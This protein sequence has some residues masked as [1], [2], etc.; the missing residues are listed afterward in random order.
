MIKNEEK[1]LKRC[2]EAVENIV[3][4]FCIC[5]TGS[6]DKSLEIA[7]EFLK[8]HKGCLT[9]EPWKNFG[10]N[11]TV[12][13]QNAQKYIKKKLKWNTSKVY[14]LLLD[15][16]MVFV[17]NN[18]KEQKLTETGY[19]IIQLNG[20]LEYYNCRFVRMDFPWK[21]VGVTHEYWDGPTE[22][23]PKSVCYINDVN[24]GG[25]KHDKFERD[26]KLLRQ[27]LIDEPENVRYLFYLAQTLKCTRNFTESIKYYK[28]R[29]KSGGWHEEVWYSHYMIGECYLNLNNMIKFEKWMQLAHQFHPAR[30]ESLAKLTEHFRIHGLHYK[31]YH[32]AKI[33]DSIPF[34]QND[35]LF[36]E[37][38]IYNGKFLY[39]KSILDYYV[40]QDKKIGLRDSFN[41]LLK[42]GEH[43]NNVISNLK[44]Y[45]SPIFVD[46]TPL[47]IPQVFGEDFRPSAVSVLDYPMANIRFV[48]Y[49]PPLDGGFRTKN[50]EDVQTFNAYI[51]IETKE[52]KLMN[53]D[54]V[55]LP[56][57]PT[58]VKGL[59]DI[60]LTKRNNEVWFTATNIRE[61][62]PAVRVITGKYNFENG[63]Y[64]NTSVLK[65]PKN[66]DCEKNW[67]P[68]KDT[69]LMIYGW[70]PYCLIDTESNITL[71]IPTPPLFS[72]FR[73]SA[74]PVKFTDNTHICLVHFV[75]YTKIR[76]YYHC[77][78]ELD[79]NYKPIKLSLP[80]VFNS[81]SI[82]YCLSI[83]K[84]DDVIE[85]FPG[86][87]ESDPHKVRINISTLEWLSF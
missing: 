5:D 27:G 87:M 28:K 1:I 63:E 30:T 65:S 43:I 6:T 22:S 66:L 29:I 79:Q 72:L 62:D 18:L 3:D 49:L 59:E 37:T 57:F 35:I 11:R 58:N 61:Y 14:G 17:S 71:T 16:D 81:V 53:D 85:C 64:E 25:C 82:E 84:V 74:P 44:F 21:C 40:N 39:E 73:G 46:K 24:D 19:K 36:V 31:A 48:N 33:G 26:E 23:L 76:N 56:R 86:F 69:N 13:F 77:F 47:N 55:T 10:H 50:G 34:P 52:F 4:C 41:Y 83:R 2:L 51:N 70:Y 20:G 38:N 78:V 15:A 7:E 8:T 75:E 32:Y 68:I 80:F 12:S 54:S 42:N 45:V 67:L 9:T 60:R